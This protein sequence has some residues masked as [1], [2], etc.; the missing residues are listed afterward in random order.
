MLPA[1]IETRRA[2]GAGADALSQL[3][4]A[5]FKPERDE[6][7]ALLHRAVV[8]MRRGFADAALPEKVEE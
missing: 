7:I 1:L 8:A 3:A 4:L 6:A 5:D 2:L